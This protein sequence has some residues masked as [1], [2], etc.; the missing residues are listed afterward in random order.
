MDCRKCGA[1]TK[2]LD[3]FDYPDRVERRRRC[4]DLSCSYRFVTV[5]LH[6]RESTVYGHV[7]KTARITPA[8]VKEV[9]LLL[10]QG[11]LSQR[12]IGERLGLSQQ[13]IS[14]IKRGVSWGYVQA[15]KNQK[16]L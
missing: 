3:V 12:E 15:P 13:Q 16:D 6:H 9:K 11:T 8:E 7:P 2:V 14:K 10:A 4:L 1:K 5:E